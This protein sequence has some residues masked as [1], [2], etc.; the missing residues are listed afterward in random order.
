[1]TEMLIVPCAV[2]TVCTLEALPSPVPLRIYN[3]LT[4]MPW[5]TLMHVV[6]FV[7]IFMVFW[8]P[9]TLSNLRRQGL[10]WHVILIEFVCL[11]AEWTHAVLWFLMQ[12]VWLESDPQRR[13]MKVW[14]HSAIELPC[15]LFLITVDL[16]MTISLEYSI[17][18][19]IP[20]R[21]LLP[22]FTSQRIGRTASTVARTLWGLRY[23]LLLLASVVV[24]AGA[25]GLTLFEGAVNSEDGVE[26]YGNSFDSFLASTLT[27]FVFIATGENYVDIV[28][29][30][31]EYSGYSIIYFM[32]FAFVGLFFVVSILIGSF[33]EGYGELETE[34]LR[35]TFIKSR[36]VCTLM[37]L[38]CR[39][40]GYTR[41]IQFT[42]VALCC[43]T[44]AGGGGGVH[45]A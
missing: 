2:I 9:D 35:N 25:L 24:L 12:A 5:K 39:C 8:E 40:T 45:F 27:M 31:M 36:T 22:L 11:T 44:I 33:E 30:A 26:E 14:R 37:L 38:R 32:V 6:V 21:P 20:L 29:P 41:P 10:D 1:M 3:V 42:C 23:I 13:G 17:E 43:V 34:H 19:F 7:H 4:S 28:Y 16:I 15:L 18:Y